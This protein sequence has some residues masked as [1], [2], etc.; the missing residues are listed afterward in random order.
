M[1]PDPAIDAV[2]AA[3][4]AISELCQHDPRKLIDHYMKRQESHRSRLLAPQ[5]RDAVKEERNN[6]VAGS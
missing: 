5:N 2:R 3:R 1:K 4:H 6:W